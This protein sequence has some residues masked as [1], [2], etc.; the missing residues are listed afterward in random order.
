M[1]DD[2]IPWLEKA[3]SSKRYEA[4]HYPWYN[5]GRV[6]AEKDMYNKAKECFRKCLEVEPGYSSAREALDAVSR[7]VH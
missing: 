2:A 6:Y 3:I 1:Y 5:L 7:L 4:V